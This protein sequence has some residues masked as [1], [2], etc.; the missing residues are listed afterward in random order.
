MN[1]NEFG[2]HSAILSNYAH[3]AD[4]GRQRYDFCIFD[5]SVLL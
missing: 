1:T 2:R 5:N 4:F 3:M